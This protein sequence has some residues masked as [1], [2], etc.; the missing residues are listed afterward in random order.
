MIT[1]Q[2]A[3][4]TQDAYDFLVE[5]TVNP[6]TIYNKTRSEKLSQL[7]EVFEYLLGNETENPIEKWFSTNEDPALNHQRYIEKLLTK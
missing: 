4:R 5:E 2:I 1:R 6:D 7:L 3:E